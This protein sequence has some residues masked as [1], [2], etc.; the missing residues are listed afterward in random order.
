MIRAFLSVTMVMMESTIVWNIIF[1]IDRSE[2]PQP[3]RGPKSLVLPPSS[4]ALPP[5]R[6][7]SSKK[8]RDREEPELDRDRTTNLLTRYSIAFG[9]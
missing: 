4:L 5:C 7:F 3:G 8:S 6:T 2:A 9:F 1:F